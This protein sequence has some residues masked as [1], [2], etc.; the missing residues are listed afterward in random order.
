MQTMLCWTPKPKHSPC[1]KS[2]ITPTTF[3][4]SQD[5]IFRNQS[6]T[7]LEQWN[8]IGS[9]IIGYTIDCIFSTSNPCFVI[10]DAWF[11][12]YNHRHKIN[13]PKLQ[14]SWG[15]LKASLPLQIIAT[16]WLMT[17]KSTYAAATTSLPS[18]KSS[19]VLNNRPKFVLLDLFRLNQKKLD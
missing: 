12:L 14:S 11:L 3:N 5:Q 10:L 6:K 19:L 1:T 2:N 7:H 18:P 8:N 9:W 15:W 4:M 16:N 17:M 13:D